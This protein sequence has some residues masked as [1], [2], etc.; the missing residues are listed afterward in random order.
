LVRASRGREVLAE[1]LI[2]AGGHVTQVVAY[3][4][5]DVPVAEP[6][7]VAAMAAG[8][9]HWTTVTSSA[10]ARSLIRLFG[11]ALHQTRLISI[12]P[13]TSQMLREAGFEPT[14]EASD[15]SMEGLVAALVQVAGS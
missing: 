12:S 3:H 4:S 8:N 1:T 15:Y 5:G 2:A 9:I 13:I 11:P 7:I 14:V 10:I 6:E